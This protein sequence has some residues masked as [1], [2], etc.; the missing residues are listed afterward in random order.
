MTDDKGA[1][2]EKA[3]L[4]SPAASGGYVRPKGNGTGEVMYTHSLHRH[5][6]GDYLNCLGCA[7]IEGRKAERER[8]AKIAEKEY[9]DIPECMVGRSISQKIM[10]GEDEE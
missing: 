3:Q 5:M 6:L 7:Y 10:G 9:G 1:D 8:C 4:G 2:M